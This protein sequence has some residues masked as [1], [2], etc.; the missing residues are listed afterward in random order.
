MTD[1]FRDLC[2]ELADALDSELDL[3]ETR[4]SELLDRARAAL[5]EEA[6]APAIGPEWQPCVKLPITVHV[7]EQRPGENHVSTREGITPLRPD[8][9]IMR[10]VQGEEYPIG[11]ELFNRTYRMGEAL[12]EGDGVGPADAEVA[13][14]VVVLRADAECVSAEQPDLMQIT[15]AQLSR[16]ADLLEQGTTHPRPIPV[17]EWNEDDGDVLWWRLPVKESPYVGSPL[18]DDWVPG[19]YTHFTRL[20]VP[21]TAIPLP[22]ASP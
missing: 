5:A 1:T 13:E 20:Q 3:F 11:R 9:L 10:G 19:Y 18:W 12:A 17:A 4:H 22:E 16:A 7:R 15:D 21:A 14:L 2:G 8:D 6:G